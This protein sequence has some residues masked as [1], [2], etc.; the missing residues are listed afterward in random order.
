[1]WQTI[2]ASETD[3]NSPLNQTLMD[4]VRGNLDHL[5]SVGASMKFVN[6]RYSNTATPADFVLDNNM[7]W[8]DRFIQVVGSVFQGTN[9]DCDEVVLGGDKDIK[10]GNQY[11]PAPLSLRVAPFDH[12]FYSSA[13]SSARQD[14]PRLTSEDALGD[15]DVFIWVNSSTGH[16]M[17]S[18]VTARDSGSRNLVCH[19]RLAWSEDQGAH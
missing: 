6:A 14:D 5:Y 8:R 9:S 3:A 15:P 12:W 1:M 16:L 19:L 13:G 2:A 17:V 4:K 11:L 18:A 10:I 7:D